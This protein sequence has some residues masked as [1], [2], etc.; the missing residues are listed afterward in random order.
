MSC[1][2]EEV[3]V[4]S[5]DSGLLR[6]PLSFKTI[7][8]IGLLGNRISFQ[9]TRLFSVRGSVGVPWSLMSLLSNGLLKKSFCCLFERSEAISQ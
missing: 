8:K 1:I 9:I 6:K 4:K 2:A 7:Q 5:G 3:R